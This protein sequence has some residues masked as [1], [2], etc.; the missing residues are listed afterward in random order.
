[1]KRIFDDRCDIL[2]YPLDNEIKDMIDKLLG[3]Y[4]NADV[5]LYLTKLYGICSYRK[6]I[7]ND[8]DSTK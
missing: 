1:M 4:D 6:Q 2:E 7:T 3:E 8:W 5:L